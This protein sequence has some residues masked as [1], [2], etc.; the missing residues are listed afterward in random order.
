MRHI[1]ETARHRAHLTLSCF[2]MAQP[3]HLQLLITGPKQSQLCA[4]W[5]PLMHYL[6][7][8]FMPSISIEA[9]VVQ[10]LLLCQVEQ[11]EVEVSQVAVDHFTENGHQIPTAGH[12]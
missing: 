4:V 12:V 3:S 10:R 8:T 7:A 6:E 2:T 5:R 1:L 11:A 9:Q